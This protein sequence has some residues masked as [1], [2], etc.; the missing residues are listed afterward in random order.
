[1]NLPIIALDLKQQA[2]SC[3]WKHE[4]TRLASAGSIYVELIRDK[5]EWVVIRIADHKQVYN[6]WMTTYS[7]APGDLRFEE[8]VEILKKPFGEVGD[9]L[10]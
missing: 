5:R 4:E 6:R 2:K 9:V 1:M 10:L 7:I 3:G 8:V